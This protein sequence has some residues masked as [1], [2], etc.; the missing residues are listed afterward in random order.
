MRGLEGDFGGAVCLESFDPAAE[1]EAPAVASDEAWETVGWMWRRKIVAALFAEGEERICHDGA[2]R[3]HALIVSIGVAAAISEETR[4][5]ICGTGGEL[6]AEDVV[7][8][9]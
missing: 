2:N 9:K 6:G 1:A 4:H 8:H 3:V 5:G 7:G